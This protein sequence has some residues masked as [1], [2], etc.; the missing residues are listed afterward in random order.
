MPRTEAPGRRARVRSRSRSR[1]RRRTGALLFGIVLAAAA[2]LGGTTATATAAPAPAPDSGTPLPRGGGN[3]PGDIVTA[4]PSVFK[5][6]PTATADVTSWQIT[7]RSTGATG[8]PNVVSGT[9]LV[10]ND[11]AAGPDSP[12][13]LISYAVGTVGLGDQCAPSAGFPAGTTAEG[14]LIA[15]LLARGWAVAVTDYEGLGTPGTHTY[16]VARSAGKAVLDAARAA[17]RLPGAA[18]LGITADS[19][20]GLMGYSQ[21]G[22]SVSWAAQLQ[23]YYAP[24]LDIAGTVTGGTPSRLRFAE[25]Q[26]DSPYGVGFTLMS[27]IGQDAAYPGLNLDR[28]LNDT[29]RELAARMAQGCVN[30][31][32]AAGAAYSLDD[33]TRSDPA[34][35][36]RWRF[37]LA[38]QDLGGL[39]PRH[40][41]FV[42]H[43]DADDLIPPQ[44]GSELAESWCRRGATVHAETIPGADHLGAVRPGSMRGA[45]WLAERFAG[46]PATGNCTP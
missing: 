15:L 38:Q 10:P 8:R 30:E 11:G 31:N 21:G 3:K 20:V 9:V 5:P 18:G 12:R 44:L 45:D 6:T 7:Y 36:R 13:P 16:T 37:R 2:S 14:G 40:P 33:I 42:Y 43:G 35:T 46:L 23:P 4:R 29:G 24:D 41:V 28:F 1:V 26:E 34:E 22:Q 19:P 17:R 32:I 39:A 27:L 25:L